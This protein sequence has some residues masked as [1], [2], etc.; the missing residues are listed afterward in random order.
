MDYEVSG[1][2]HGQAFS[3]AQSTEDLFSTSSTTVKDRIT[4]INTKTASDDQH[5]S[6]IPRR[7]GLG[8]SKGVYPIVTKQTELQAMFDKRS[9]KEIDP[10]LIEEYIQQNKMKQQQNKLEEYRQTFT[11]GQVTTADELERPYL[12]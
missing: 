8:K 3:P 12:Y 7:K 6:A 9:S 11:A 2:A 4:A 10:Q 1:N 5:S